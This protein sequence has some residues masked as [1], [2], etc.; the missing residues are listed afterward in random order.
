MLERKEIRDLKEVQELKPDMGK[1]IHA[2][3]DIPF[4][5]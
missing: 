2:L 5:E 1:R 4:G 3:E